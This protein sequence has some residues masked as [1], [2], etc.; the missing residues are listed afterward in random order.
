MINAWH[1]LIRVHSCYSHSLADS[2]AHNICNR[3]IHRVHPLFSR[4][5][6]GA[7]RWYHFLAQ[8]DRVRI[9]IKLQ[10]EEEV[11]MVV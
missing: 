2:N 8:P 10:V 6:S 5:V 4:P 9:V 7:T 11:D 1:R 3:L